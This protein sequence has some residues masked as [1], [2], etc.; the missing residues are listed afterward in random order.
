MRGR[1]WRHF[2]RR[3]NEEEGRAGSATRRIR[4]R[5]RPQRCRRAGDEIVERTTT[6]VKP[7]PPPQYLSPPSWIHDDNHRDLHPH[8]NTPHH[9]LLLHHEL[10]T[11]RTTTIHLHRHLDTEAPLSSPSPSSF[12]SRLRIPDNTNDISDSR[13]KFLSQERTTTIVKPQPPPQSSSSLSWIHDDNHRDLHPHVNTPHHHLLLHHEL[14]TPRTTT[15]HLHRQLDTEAPPSSLSPSSLP[16]WLRISDNAN[17]MEAVNNN[18]RRR[19]FER[20]LS[21]SYL[22]QAL[23]SLRNKVAVEVVKKR[24][25]GEGGVEGDG[26][27]R[28]RGWRRY[29]RR[30]NE[31]ERRASG[32]TRRIRARVKQQR[33]RRASEEI[34]D[35]GNL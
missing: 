5:V 14:D 4:E 2:E 22:I 19:T 12:P 7:Q 21:N 20:E 6:I 16:S 15:I 31:K 8:V 28:G 33:C 17:D 27:M 34:V 26:R 24:E 1:G 35:K 9:H 18:E 10:D 23:H 11:P 30:S 13:H 32:V 29:G 3:S 25:R